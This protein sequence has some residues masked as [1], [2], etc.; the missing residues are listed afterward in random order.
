MSKYDISA[1]FISYDAATQ[2]WLSGLDPS[3]GKSDDE[4]AQIILS[5]AYAKPFD[6]TDPDMTGDRDDMLSAV[7]GKITSSSLS[8]RAGSR[9]EVSTSHAVK[10]GVCSAVLSCLSGATCSFTQTI[11]KAPRSKCQS[12]GGQ[13]CCLS[14]S[15]YT[16]KAG[17]FQTTWT[18]CNNEV[19]AQGKTSASCEGYGSVSQGGDVCLSSR[20]AGCT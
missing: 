8:K 20:A 6:S 4:K 18:T 16:V 15:D 11:N 7:A 1:E 13:S 14:W 3:T 19:K 2:A 9:F 17:F 5:A 10:W 12:A